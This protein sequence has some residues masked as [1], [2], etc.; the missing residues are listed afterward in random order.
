MKEENEIEEENELE[1]ESVK[2]YVILNLNS[3]SIGNR[4][5]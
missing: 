4:I 2:K 3:K 5:C 1:F